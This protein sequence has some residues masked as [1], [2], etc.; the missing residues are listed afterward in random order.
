MIWRHNTRQDLC[1][2]GGNA[3]PPRQLNETALSALDCCES[4]GGRVV[5]LGEGRSYKPPSGDASRRT[6]LVL[7]DLARGTL[8]PE[9]VYS[10]ALKM[11]QANDIGGK[12][13][14][15]LTWLCRGC[16]QIWDGFEKVGD[17]N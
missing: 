1:L 14:A 9:D 6:S 3:Y 8:S 16:A 17:T 4:S 12:D 15:L 7:V 2:N 10:A 13:N 11:G 5:D